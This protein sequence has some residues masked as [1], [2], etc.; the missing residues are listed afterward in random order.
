MSTAIATEARYTPEDLLVMS[1]SKS[2]ELVD[3]RL[4]ERRSGALSSWVG[5][6]LLSRLGWYCEEHRLGW[7]LPASCGYQCFP[8][9]PGRVRRPNVSFIR[10]GRFPGGRLPKGF[11]QIVPD[12]VVGVVAPNDLVEELEEKLVDY[13]KAGV[14]LVWVISHE[15]R[16]VMVYRRD[17]SVARLREDDELS[18][19]DVIPGFRCPIRE[20]L[21]LQE[22]PKEGQQAPAGPT[23]LP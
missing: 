9:D 15:S 10:Y 16:R 20:V 8:H 2:Y 17:G 11:A 22:M 23:G 18:G 1:D 14:P 21:P 12:L 13:E 19:E 4:A 5:G 7:V 3:G 6:Q